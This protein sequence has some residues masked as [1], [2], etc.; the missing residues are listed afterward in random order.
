MRKSFVQAARERLSVSDTNS[1]ETNR[2]RLQDFKDHP[3]LYIALVASGLLS[4][5]AGAVLG[6][7]VHVLDGDVKIHADFPHIFFAVIYAILFPAFFEYGLA[8]WLHKLLHREDK[9][10]TQYWISMIMV[11]VTFIGTTVTAFSAI[12][13]IVTAGGFFTAF[14][15]V[16]VEVQRWIA[17]S[18]PTMFMINIAAGELYRHSSSFAQLRRLA[19]TELKGKQLDADLEMDLAKVEMEKNVAILA[20]ARYSENAVAEQKIIS[21]SIGDAQWNKDSQNLKM[22]YA[23]HT[24]GVPDFVPTEADEE[25]QTDNFS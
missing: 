22:R 12:D 24:K 7:G 10:E 16:P 9:N 11:G 15:E 3:L 13:V 20:A 23:A 21:E 17:F 8:N 1:K 6:L 4:M 5:I 14:N 2:R 25:T 19:E 18:L